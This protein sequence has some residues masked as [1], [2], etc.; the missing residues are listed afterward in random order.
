M[1]IGL[2]RAGYLG[3]IA[4]WIG[5]TLPSAIILVLFGLGV[6]KFQIGESWLHGLKI[7]AVAVVAQALWAMAKKLCPDRQRASIAVA[8][9]VL[10]AA[11]PSTLTQLLVIVLGGLMGI[12]SLRNHEVLPH[13]PLHS[14]RNRVTAGILLFVF[15]VLL[16]LLPIAAR[17]SDLQAIKL[18][19]SFFSC[20]F[21]CFRRRSR[22]SSAFAN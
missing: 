10:I 7:V 18:F 17:T 4:A 13:A 20:R 16:I 8:A 6:S 5:F 2:S 11:F 21:A 22:C 19:D 1:A 14:E 15:A 12:I 3:A 9:A